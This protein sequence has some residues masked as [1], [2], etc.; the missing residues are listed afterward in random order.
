LE[1]TS[2]RFRVISESPGVRAE[3]NVVQLG[4]NA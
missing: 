3:R 2:G 4:D 1:G